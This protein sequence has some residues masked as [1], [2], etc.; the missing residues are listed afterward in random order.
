[1]ST[2]ALL[3]IASSEQNP[4]LYYRTRFYVPDPCIYIEHEGKRILILS[5]LEI[6]RGRKLAEVDVVLSLTEFR[7]TLPGDR[8]GFA[9]IVDAV[10]KERGIVEAIVPWD[11]PLKYADALRALGYRVSFREEPFFPERLHK[12][13]IEVRL[14]RQAERFAEQA[15]G[16]AIDIIARSEIR[17][18]RLYV[19]GSILTSERIKGEINSCLARVGC[20]ATHTIVAS[21]VHGSMPHH[22]GEGPILPHV[23]VVIDIFPRVV[24]T[25]YYGDITRTVV[26]GN[27]SPE[28][29]KMY[30]TVL[31]GQRLA[32]SLIRA[33]VK[34][35]D[36]HE[37]IHRLFEQEG[38]KT[39]EFGGRREGFIHST[40]HGLG[41]EIHEPPRITDDDTV[42]EEGMVVTVEPG[43]YYRR[44]GGVRIEDVVLVTKEGYRS[45]T[46]FPKR[47][48]V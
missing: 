8:K 4:N 26:K 44:L 28:A 16:L 27:P 46:R 12:T 25:G 21:G 31:R 13:P 43:L 5:D 47:F 17:E 18:G 1:M 7:K 20:V 30:R 35:R 48:V 36:V 22:G 23:P 11:F 38:F 32:L 33:G 34:G 42:L 2:S 6:D 40:G 10:F 19:D 45:L 24:A 41:L 15:M 14:I 29:N 39:G 9:S 37:A 3:I